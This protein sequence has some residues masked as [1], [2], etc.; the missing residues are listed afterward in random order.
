MHTH[1]KQTHCR[2]Q[3]NFTGKTNTTTHRANYHP[4]I[5]TLF[6]VFRIYWIISK[7]INMLLCTQSTRVHIII[8]CTW[9]NKRSPTSHDPK[10][11]TLC[12]CAFCV[13][14]YIRECALICL[15]YCLVV[16]FFRVCAQR[17]RKNFFLL[18]SSNSSFFY[19]SYFSLHFSFVV[20]FRGTFCFFLRRLS[21]SCCCSCLVC[22]HL[23]I[24]F[25]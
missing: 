22:A 20:L 3:K 21:L 17:K 8:Q 6:R 1:I 16:V 23:F 7:K 2:K 18:F 24:L 25:V 11:A 14:K 4:C 12:Q 5:H 15:P 19:S 10:C 9:L 13:Y